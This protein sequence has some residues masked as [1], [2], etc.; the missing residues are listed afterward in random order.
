[1]AMY[2]FQQTQSETKNLLNKL[3]QETNREEQKK[4][5]SDKQTNAR[6]YK[7]KNAIQCGSMKF[8][9]KIVYTHTQLLLLALVSRCRRRYV[10]VVQFLP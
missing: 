1:M 4:I 10:A 7:K 3:M 2:S 6:I 9:T 8:A 5:I